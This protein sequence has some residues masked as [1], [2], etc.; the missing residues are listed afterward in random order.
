MLNAEVS[1][2]S[3]WQLHNSLQHSAFSIATGGPECDR[4]EERPSADDN[5]REG[6]ARDVA[7]IAGL[8]GGTRR[9]RDG[10]RRHPAQ[11]SKCAAAGS[12]AF[13]LADCR[14]SSDCAVRHSGLLRQSR[15]RGAHVA[16][17]LLASFCDAPLTGGLGQEP[18]AVPPRPACAAEARRR[19]EGRADSQDSH[20]S[21]QT[22]LR[23]LVLVADHTAYHVG[24]LVLVRQQ[25][26]IWTVKRG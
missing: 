13:A 4:F 3:N 8:G 19:P 7:P 22:Y 11:A 6:V 26:G 17:R 12:P 16:R 10:G 18:R 15:L 24:Q 14:A 25:L 9:V 5:R 20:G 2:V 1:W 23:E 21:G